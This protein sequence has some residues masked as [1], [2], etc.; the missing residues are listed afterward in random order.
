MQQVS[1]DST[2]PASQAAHEQLQQESQLLITPASEA[3]HE[4]MQQHGQDTTNLEANDR[5][6]EPGPSNNKRKRGGSQMQ[7]V[8]GR[9]E[10]KLIVLNEFDQPIGPTKE[11]VADLSFF[12]GTLARNGIFC[13]LN[14]FD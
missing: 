9:R 14:V 12:L 10:R 5:A 1:L 7:K 8:H 4:Q 3:V 11:V 13:P 2:I 6:N